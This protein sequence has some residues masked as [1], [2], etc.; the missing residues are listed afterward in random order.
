MEQLVV[1]NTS[2]WNDP[3]QSNQYFDNGRLIFINSEY[4]IYVY[5]IDQLNCGNIKNA[6][7]SSEVLAISRFFFK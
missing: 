3:I 4:E 6:Q 2:H 7:K 1:C 5:D